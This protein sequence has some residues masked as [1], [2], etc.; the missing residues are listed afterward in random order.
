MSNWVDT[1]IIQYEEG[2]KNL[3]RHHARLG[4]SK[5]DQLDK[6]Q[7]N[8]MISSM[9]YSIDWM[10]RGRRPGNLRGVD[11]RNA[12]QKRALVDV[13]LMPSLN[14]QPKPRELSENEKRAIYEL[15]INLS[16]RER[17]CYLLHYAEGWSMQQIADELT[18]SKSSVQ[19]FIERAKKKINNNKFCHTTV[20]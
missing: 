14:I 15:L 16:H 8:S 2:R 18:I 17:Q 4:D 11:K 1:L 12:Y 19:K 9:T 6:S 13:E 5:I 3:Q 20:V 7:I 10:K